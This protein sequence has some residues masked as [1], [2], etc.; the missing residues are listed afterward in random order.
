MGFPVFS[1][2]ANNVRSVYFWSLSTKTIGLYV[3][4]IQNG[5]ETLFIKFIFYV[6]DENL[7]I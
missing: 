7:K 1:I 2:I 4:T 3:Y 5:F 6:S